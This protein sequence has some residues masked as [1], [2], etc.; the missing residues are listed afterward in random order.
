MRGLLTAL[1]LLAFAVPVIAAEKAADANPA[2]AK[3]T[4]GGKPGTNVD[5]PFLMAPMTGTDGKLSGYAY[6]STRLTASSESVALT[7]RDRIAF[8]QDAFVRDVNGFGVAKKDDAT[9]VDMPALEARLLADAKKV[10]GAG[11]VVSINIVQLQIAPLHP[12]ETPALNTPPPPLD[13]G[14]KPA[15]SKKTGA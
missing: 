12:T 5:M 1:A 7:V 10:M 6:I 9:Q 3:D 11:K 15:E 13:S 8:V 2:D 4:K 14:G